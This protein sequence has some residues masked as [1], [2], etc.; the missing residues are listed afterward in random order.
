MIDFA[1]LI[2]LIQCVN[3]GQIIVLF[4]FKEINLFLIDL[5]Q[6]IYLILHIVLKSYN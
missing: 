3:I 1:V 5:I 6:H 4:L 2:N